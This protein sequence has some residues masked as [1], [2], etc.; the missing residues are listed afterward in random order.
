MEE[1]RKELIKQPPWAKDLI[2]D[3]KTSLV[4]ID[5]TYNEA[6][7]IRGQGEKL[8]ADDCAT[9]ADEIA[10]LFKNVY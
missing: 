7:A 6:I 3:V 9:C 10:G 4:W 2:E 1:L 5:K 8:P